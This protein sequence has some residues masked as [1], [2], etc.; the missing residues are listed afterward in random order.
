MNEKILAFS[1]TATG[2]NH[3]KIEKGCED[4]SDFYMDDKM[5]ICVVAD[6]HGSDNYPRTDRG[7]EYA[8]E[9]AIECIVDFVNTANSVDVLT[10]EKNH[11]ALMLQLVT[12]ILRIWHEK[13]DADYKKNPFT[14]QE[15]E[16]VTDKYKQRYLSPNENERKVEKAYGCTLI[17]FVCTDE[18][19]FGLQIG[20]GKCVMVDKE[21][22]FSEPIPWD[23]NCQMNVTTSICDGDA[24]DEFRYF[25]TNRMPASVFCGSDGID[26]SY[27]STEELYAL[28][29]SMLKIF[30]E[31][32]SEVGMS[33]IKDYL[34][35]LSKR[36]SGDDVSVALIL[37]MNRL[38]VLA[39]ILDKQG[40]LFA[41]DSEL[42][43]KKH[44]IDIMN[45]RK[46]Q[47][48]GQYRKWVNLGR[49]KV[50]TKPSY[51]LNDLAAA[52][53]KMECELEDIVKRRKVITDAIQ[54]KLFDIEQESFGTVDVSEE[55]NADSL[56]SEMPANAEDIEGVPLSVAE[57]K[58]SIVEQQEMITKKALD[59]IAGEYLSI[60]SEDD[61]VEDSAEED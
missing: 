4:A 56:E 46:N 57:K 33:E 9:A 60:A 32:G 21:G 8:V 10:D 47:T 14:E 18:Y 54:D 11:Y 49:P 43:E 53:D 26:D 37:D 50:D 30:I 48:E 39:D 13:I 51:V 22:N 31:H 44:Q 7:S 41:I 59:E 2:Y 38:K 61:K 23:E 15:L 58:I 3:I 40:E 52:I 24:R 12:S 35:N 55:C 19:S 25:I 17:A 6:G 27:A 16:K 1:S 45:E 34:P 28:Y 5:R 20:D 36:G 42:R 29:R